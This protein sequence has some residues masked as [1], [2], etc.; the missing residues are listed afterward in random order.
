MG[1]IIWLQSTNGDWSNKTLL[2]P[3]PTGYSGVR[4]LTVTTPGDG[5]L[6][7]F[8]LGYDEIL[9]P[10]G[11]DSDQFVIKDLLHR[12]WSNSQW[13]AWEII[14]TTGFPSGVTYGNERELTSEMA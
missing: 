14:P 11:T 3:R 9:N 10:D 8:G 2:G 6:D 5:T 7:L 12:K 1:N 13:S 4:F